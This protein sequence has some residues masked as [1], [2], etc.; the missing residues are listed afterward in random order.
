MDKPE[1]DF[2]RASALM[3]VVQ[4]VATIAPKYMNLSSM[5]MAELKAMD[6]EAKA[7]NDAEAERIK[8]EAEAQRQ[9]EIEAAQAEEETSIENENP[10]RG[11]AVRRGPRVTPY[12]DPSRPEIG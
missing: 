10:I 12:N 5:A 3:D 4:K 2:A 9:T 6:E 1:I 7:W 8:A 11:P